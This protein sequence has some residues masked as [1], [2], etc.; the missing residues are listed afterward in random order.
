[1]ATSSSFPVSQAAEH[2]LFT[3]RDQ[4]LNC[5]AAQG[6]PA[7]ARVAQAVLPLGLGAGL[8]PGEHLLVTNSCIEARHNFTVVNVPGP[9][10]RRI[11]ILSRYAGMV[12]ELASRYPDKPLAGAA[13]PAINRLN[14][15]IAIVRRPAGL[16]NL[17]AARARSIWIT[18]LIAA[19]VR[20]PEFMA[21]AGVES[22]QILADLVPY[23][24]PIDERAVY[25]MIASAAE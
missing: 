25:R 8:R 24:E 23:V 12:V 5:A 7:W 19:G 22:T 2:T 20:F 4:W 18:T 21:A 6:T 11:P 14:N 3:R 10:P 13:S 1:M 15:L 17:S 9:C 16:A